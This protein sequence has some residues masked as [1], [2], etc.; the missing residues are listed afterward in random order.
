MTGKKIGILLGGVVVGIGSVCLYLGQGTKESQP[1]HRPAPSRQASVPSDERPFNAGKDK[2]LQEETTP[3][4]HPLDDRATVQAGLKAL[5]RIRNIPGA[6]PLLEEVL[7]FIRNNPGKGVSLSQIPV[8]EDG[9]VPL[10]GSATDH[11]IRNEKIREKWKALHQ[12]I[13][14]YPENRVE[15]RSESE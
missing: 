13:A 7:E 15:R 12:L 8:D 3:R 10:D 6:A 1:V 14:R 2:F 11:M 9:L 5:D 4:V